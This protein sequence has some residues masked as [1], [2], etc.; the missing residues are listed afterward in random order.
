MTQYGQEYVIYA[1]YLNK[2]VA[3]LSA[4]EKR[5][6]IA[7]R[8]PKGVYIYEVVDTLILHQGQKVGLNLSPEGEAI[9]VAKGVIVPF[10]PQGE[11]AGVKTPKEVKGG[12][13]S[14]DSSND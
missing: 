10:S 9:L 7:W 3:R 14:P 13:N 1:A 11:V 5:A 6:A 8:E 4:A 12:K 2:P